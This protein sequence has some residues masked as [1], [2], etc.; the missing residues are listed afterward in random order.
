MAAEGDIYFKLILILMQNDMQH[1][2]G[3]NKERANIHM[4]L[5]LLGDD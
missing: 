3:K 1:V 4:Y 5:C 2:C